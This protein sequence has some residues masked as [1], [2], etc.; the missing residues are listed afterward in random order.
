MTD[1][2]A[3]LQY[4][5]E[6]F[7]RMRLDER[8]KDACGALEIN[9]KARDAGLMGSTLW[10]EEDAAMHAVLADVKS[11]RWI[12]DIIQPDLDAGTQVFGPDRD[13]FERW[14]KAYLIACALAE[15]WA[16]HED[17]SHKW[18]KGEVEP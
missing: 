12:L 16:D 18:A 6:A 3:Q 10:E 1:T 2:R 13:G 15:P 9:Q 17:Y 8:E 5:P 7:V 4:C 11:K 14:G